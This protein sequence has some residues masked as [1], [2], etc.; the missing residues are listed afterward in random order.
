MKNS[1]IFYIV[2]LGA[3]FGGIK[4]TANS[5]FEKKKANLE[6]TDFHKAVTGYIAAAGD[7]IAQH[8]SGKTLVIY[9]WNKWCEPCMADLTKLNK[10]A[11]DHA[12]VMVLAVTGESKGDVASVLAEKKLKLDV[13]L[14][15]EPKW[16]DMLVIPIS[17]VYGLN[18]DPENP[19]ER[20]PE[21]IVIS[22]TG[23][24][25]LYSVGQ[26]KDLFGDIEKALK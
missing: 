16:M 14:I 21:V 4:W 17:Q 12:N 15:C 3:A 19:R 13:P 22:P 25:L 1:I 9:N 24:V 2:L 7:S 20:R 18:D 11:A 5:L 6:K 26:K 8:T 10:L 23:K